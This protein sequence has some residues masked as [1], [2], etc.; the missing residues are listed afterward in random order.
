MAHRR[1]P[2]P[3]PPRLSPFPFRAIKGGTI[4]SSSRAPPFLSSRTAP[5]PPRNT[6]ATAA[7]RRRSPPP[8]PLPP[9]Q[10]P[11]EPKH[12]PLSLL[13][14]FP[15]DLRHGSAFPAFSGEPAAAAAAWRRRRCLA[16]AAVA[17]RPPRPSDEDLRPRLKGLRTP[18]PGPR[19]TGGP[20]PPGRSTRLRHRHVMLTSLLASA[21]PTTARHVSPPQSTRRL[22]WRFCKKNPEVSQ[23][24]PSTYVKAFQSGPFF[25]P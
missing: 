3:P 21:R 17:Y 20:G 15:C 9:L 13:V 10:A 7:P 12:P 5:P 6:A 4:S 2:T 24:C 25:Y 23:I 8:A 19:W 11:G 18:S 1:A 16:A 14:S 22:P